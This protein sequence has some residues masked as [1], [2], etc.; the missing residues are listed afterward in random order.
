MTPNSH[1][2]LRAKLIATTLAG[3]WRRSVNA[4]SISEAELAEITPLLLGSGAGALGWRRVLN[5]NLETSP[6]ASELQSAYQLHTIHALLYQHKIKQAFS[7]LRIHEIEPILIKGWANARLYPEP[8]LRPYGDIDLCVRPDQF[9]SASSVLDTQEGRE[10]WVDLHKGLGRLDERHWDEFFGRSQP[11]NLDDVKVRVLGDE[12]QLHVSCV[13]LL[14]H[15]AW[16]PIWLCDVATLVESITEKFDWDRCLGNDKRRARWVVSAIGLARQLLDARI[17]HCPAI[18]RDTLLPGWLVPN[19]LKQ[20]ERPCIKDH[21][22]PE[23]IMKSLRRPGRVPKALVNRWPDPIGSTIRLK[24]EFN[25]L[26]RLPFQ[27]CDYVG[28]YMAFAARLP[29]LLQGENRS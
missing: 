4:T 24:G 10:C 18:V 16:R 5:T 28:K 15:G 12:D 21:T 27:I 11:V 13:H 20:W 29:G 19:V 17:E 1:K 2:Q 7:L 26:P 14:D 25:E 9:Q 22:P 23:L 3:T 8:G 6:A